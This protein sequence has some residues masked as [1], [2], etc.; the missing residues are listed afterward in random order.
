MKKVLVTRLL[1]PEN[2]ILFEVTMGSHSTLLKNFIE[3]I[4]PDVNITSDK[5]LDIGYHMVDVW[6]DKE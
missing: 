4:K 6:I 1:D 5:L 2:N 3:K